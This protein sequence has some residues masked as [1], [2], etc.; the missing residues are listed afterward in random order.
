MKK[1]TLTAAVG[2]ALLFG[3]ADIYGQYAQDPLTNIYKLGGS[4]EIYMAYATSGNTFTKHGVLDVPENLNNITNPEDA[5]QFKFMELRKSAAATGDFNGDGVDEVVTVCDNI[6]GGIKITIPLLNEALE[7][8]GNREYVLEELNTLDYQRLRICTGNF[9]NDFQDEFAISYGLPNEPVRLAVFETDADLNITLLDVFKQEVYKDIY[10]DIASGDVNADGV[11]EIVM[12]K[13]ETM[14]TQVIAGPEE[15]VAFRTNYD[16]ITYAFDAGEKKIKQVAK[17]NDMKIDNFDCS[18]QFYGR[19]RS[20]E[21]RIACGDLNA[22]GKDDIVVGWCHYFCFKSTWDWD[23]WPF[24]KNYYYHFRDATYLNV[25]TLNTVSGEVENIHNLTASCVDHGLYGGYVGMHLGLSLKCEQLDNTGRDEVLVNSA[26]KFLVF[27]SNDDGYGLSKWAEVTPGA[28]NFSGNETFVVTDLNPDT[29]NMD[30]NK[31]IILLLSNKGAVDQW[32]NVADVASFQILQIDTINT[33][34]MQFKSLTPP[35]PL[36]FNDVNIDVSAL[37]TGDFDAQNADLYMIGTPEVVRVSALQYPLVILNAPPVHFDVLNGTIH[38]LCN[39]F[40][41]EEQPQFTATYYKEDAVQATTR[42]EAANSMGFSANLRAYAMAGGSGF[43]SSVTANWEK[44]KSFYNAKTD[45]ST[46]SNSKDANTEDFVL[47]SSL[48]YTYY[49][50]PVYNEEGRV[51]GKLAVLN[52]ETEF[53]SKW[54]SGNSW[55][56]PGFDLNHESGNLLSYRPYKCNTD[57]CTD[58][59][60]FRFYQY[61]SQPVSKT[62]GGGFTFTFANITSEGDSY[63]YA[64]GVGASLFTKIGVEG[65]V[66]VGVKPFGIGA[67]ISTDFRAGVSSELSANFSSSSLSSRTTELTSSFQVTGSIGGLDDSYDNVA[68]YNIIPFIYRSQ[69]GALVLDYMIDFEDGFDDWWNDNYGQQPD[70]AF[71][72]P[73]RYA[74]EKGSDQIKASMKQRTKEIQFYPPVANPGDTVTITT[75]VHNYSLEPF[76]NWLDLKFYMGDPEM[77]GVELTDIYGEQG[78]SKY[79]TMIYGAEDANLDFEE[80]LNFFWQVPDTVTCSPRIYA[81]IDPDNTYAEIHKNN[82]K[83][84]N[85]LPM[86]D[87]EDCGYIEVGLEPHVVQSVP[88]DTWPTPARDHSRVRFSLQQDGKVL[89]E[90]FSISGQRVDVVTSGWYPA[91]DHE[92]SYFAGQLEDGVYFYRMT[93]GMVTRTARLVVAK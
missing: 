89:L 32:K 11:D 74:V 87:C 91:G 68:R 53:T 60:G 46:I 15:E 48:D 30:F 57:F 6:S 25:L 83:G 31:E 23:V 59:T 13:N 41:G 43:E 2:A 17:A 80:Y 69:S 28:L 20:F 92:V 37:L 86:F 52:P 7:L 75:R 4:A 39:A 44:G 70:L 12:V 10:F 71:I 34:M 38:D 36:P 18:N 54:G 82:N 51:I 79:S 67:D 88:M 77:G 50:Y 29:A 65:S 81:V 85:V 63:S 26:T 40:L 93:S 47:F 24:T 14:Y 62:G 19:E 66:S 72:L 21:M 78:V 49:K 35:Y 61:D 55:E 73:W 76:E 42:F 58:P 90:V 33:A 84:W 8:E 45:V 27:G 1:I 56:H 3:A 22:D 9:D 16:L 64:G 5:Y